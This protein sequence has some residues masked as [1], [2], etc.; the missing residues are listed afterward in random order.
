MRRIVVL[1]LLLVLILLPLP[2]RVYAGVTWCESDPVVSLNGTLVDISVAIPL[3]YLLLVDGP[4]H[5]T[6]KTPSSV[7]RH[8]IVSDVGF[9]AHGV[10][11]DF[12]DR[13][14]G[15]DGNSF[16]TTIQVS[17]PIDESKLAPGET[18]PMKLTV[19]PLN[20]PTEVVYGTTDS[21]AVSLWITGFR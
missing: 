2:A 5:Y 6:I 19:R 3:E 21:T 13:R 7:A 10:R 9:V 4:V 17:V 14:G 20:A 16:N 18:V 15:I 8:V 12:A 11:V 1:P